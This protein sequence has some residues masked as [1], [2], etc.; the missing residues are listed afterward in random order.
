[1]V[2]LNIFWMQRLHIQMNAMPILSRGG[3]VLLKLF[4]FIGELL[5]SERDYLR[6]NF[7]MNFFKSGQRKKNSSNTLVNMDT[8]PK[9]LI[10]TVKTSKFWCPILKHDGC[11][12]TVCD[13][14]P[15]TKIFMA[16]PLKNF[17]RSADFY[18]ID[19]NIYELLCLKLFFGFIS[20]IGL[21]IIG[22]IVNLVV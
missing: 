19:L 2:H 6:I 3:L 7:G 1:M 20:Y 21:L 12:S 22:R 17:F 9:N 11:V 13:S 10:I 15:I 5:K 4:P 18:P 14:Q 8:F 16:K